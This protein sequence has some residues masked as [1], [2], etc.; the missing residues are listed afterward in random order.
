MISV[1][2]FPAAEQY[3]SRTAMSTAGTSTRI[4]GMSSGFLR[5][6]VANESPIDI[7]PERFAFHQ[8]TRFALYVYA[9]RLAARLR[10]IGNVCNVLPGCFAFAREQITIRNRQ[11]HEIS[12]EVHVGYL[13]LAVTEK[14]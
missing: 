8:A 1:R 14:Q 3:P 9:K 10:P 5:L 11:P 12:F 2:L 6:A 4:S 7:R 13:N